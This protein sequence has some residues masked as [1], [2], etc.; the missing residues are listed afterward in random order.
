MMRQMFREDLDEVLRL[1]V[2]SDSFALARFADG[3]ASVMKNMTVGNKD[4][5]LYKKD[6]NL[7]FRR[8]SRSCHSEGHTFAERTCVW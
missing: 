4:G 6:K 2:E 5:W 8:R 3:E 1:T 7:I